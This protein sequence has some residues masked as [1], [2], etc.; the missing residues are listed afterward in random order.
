MPKSTHQNRVELTHR[1]TFLSFV[2]I[3]KVL[4]VVYVLVDVAAQGPLHTHVPVISFDFDAGIHIE[5]PHSID[6]YLCEVILDDCSV[7]FFNVLGWIV[8]QSRSSHAGHSQTPS[9]Y[10]F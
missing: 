2:I 7:L 8:G 1:L 4:G 10:I 9:S 5:F 3:S 6:L